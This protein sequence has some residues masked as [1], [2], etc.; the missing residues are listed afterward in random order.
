M[1]RFRNTIFTEKILLLLLIGAFMVNACTKEDF[2]D[3]NPDE[4]SFTQDGGEQVVSIETSFSEWGV[5]QM[6]DWLSVV[7]SED[8]KLKIIVQP[9]VEPLDREG[10]VSVKAGGKYKRIKIKQAA[11]TIL[12]VSP[13]VIAF[14]YNGGALNVVIETNAKEWNVVGHP[15]WIAVQKNGNNLL[16]TVDKHIGED[17]REGKI[18]IVADQDAFFIPVTQD[19]ETILE[20]TPEHLEFDYKGGEKTVAFRANKPID[21]EYHLGSGVRFEIKTNTI[22]VEA[23]YNASPNER[24]AR[25]VL[26]SSDKRIELSVK[27]GGNRIEEEQREILTAFYYA[28]N[29][30]EWIDNTNWLSD[31]SIYEWKGIIGDPGLGVFEISLKNN[32]L[33]GKLPNEL[34]NLISLKRLILPNNNLYGEIPTDIQNL[35][36]LFWLDLSHNNL[37][38]S[39]PK[40]LINT[41]INTYLY[42]HHN[43]LTGKIPE[44]LLNSAPNFCPQ[45]SGW[46]FDNFDCSTVRPRP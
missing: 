45:Q 44:E 22:L 30:E 29:G 35:K 36:N 24:I 32:N 5:E 19:I 7:K 6:P 40:E 4:L 11:K 23:G 42:L 12:N 37:T 46:K 17:I 2:L 33:T 38:G 43:R 3:V 34:M 31:K 8:K 15:A 27:Q 41:S 10:N 16:V 14:N 39:V 26:D 20:I 21:I 13:S 1:I 9:N 18:E 25:L 28:T